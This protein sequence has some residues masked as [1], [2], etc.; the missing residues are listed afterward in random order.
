MPS[1]IMYRVY[2]HMH[3]VKAANQ[4]VPKISRDKQTDEQNFWK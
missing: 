3:L 2:I 4:K 1:F